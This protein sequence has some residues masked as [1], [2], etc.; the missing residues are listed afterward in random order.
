MTWAG[1]GWGRGVWGIYQDRAQ[2]WDLGAHDGRTSFPVLHL[3]I[4]FSLCCP[5]MGGAPYLGTVGSRPSRGRSTAILVRAAEELDSSVVR[6]I[7]RPWPPR[8][9]LSP[10][11][12]PRKQE[13]LMSKEEPAGAEK[14]NR[15]RHCTC[16]EAVQRPWGRGQ[17]C[18]TQGPEKSQ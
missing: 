16:G 18:G 14:W 5:G 1:G 13:E 10:A 8:T 11:E 12:G 7:R 6:G 15:G 4:R 2:A 9:A 3:L 17:W